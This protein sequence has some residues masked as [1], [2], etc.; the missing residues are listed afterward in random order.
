[1]SYISVFFLDSI[2]LL[3]EKYVIVVIMGWLLTNKEKYESKLSGRKMFTV[4]KI[5]GSCI[6]TLLK[7]FITSFGG[8]SNKHVELFCASCMAFR[9]PE[10]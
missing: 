2:S 1:M 10:S 9:I 5:G 6:N 3:P 4:K 8:G 7:S